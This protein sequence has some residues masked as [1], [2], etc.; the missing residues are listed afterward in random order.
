MRVII[1]HKLRTYGAAKKELLPMVEHRQHKKLN[2]RAENSHQPTKGWE[3]LM[4]RFKSAGQAQWFLSAQGP[5]RDHFR[6][7]RHKLTAPGYRAEIQAQFTIWNEVT[8]LSIGPLKSNRQPK[9]LSEV[10]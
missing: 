7:K 3:K 10:P 4:R 1:T 8:R 5:G 9:F 2:N 6:P